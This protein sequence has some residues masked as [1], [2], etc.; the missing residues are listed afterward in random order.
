MTH[1]QSKAL[2]KEAVERLMQATSGRA[3]VAELRDLRAWRTRSTAHAEAYRKAADIW[4]NLGVAAKESTTAEDAAVMAGS[5]RQRGIVSRRAIFA[6]GGAALAATVAAA[7]VRPPLGLWPSLSDFLADYH[8]AVG[9]HR[10]FALANGIS[11]EMNTQTRIARRVNDNGEERIELLAGEAAITAAPAT[12]KPLTVFA[13]DG[14]VLADKAQ[15]NVRYDADAVR[16]TCLDGT[17]RIECG[18]DA[19]ALRAREQLVYTERGIGSVKAIDPAAVTAWRQGLLI[20][21]DE[22]LTAVL[23]EVNRYWRGHIILLNGE[24]GRRRVN[25]RIELARIDEVISYVRSVL[26]ARVRTLP[27]GIVVLT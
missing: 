6:G 25:V 5:F 7:V 16:V 14:R 24:L 11:I 3:T 12:P 2:Q 18:G 1:A 13:A 9:E 17:I 19:A 26:G 8:T 15:F 23:D 20:F 4:E 21:H 22:P 27:S 10:T